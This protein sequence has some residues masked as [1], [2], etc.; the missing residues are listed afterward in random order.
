[1]RDL[2]AS[3]LGIYLGKVGLMARLCDVP[4]CENKAARS[5]DFGGTPIPPARAVTRHRIVWLCLAHQHEYEKQRL[6]L[7]ILPSD[8][9]LDGGGSSGE[10]H[11]R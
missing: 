8:I 4:G 1:M 5:V 10:P 6:D 11:D 3:T 7:N 2:V 9:R